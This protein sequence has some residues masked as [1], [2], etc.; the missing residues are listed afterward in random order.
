M[1]EATLAAL[2]RRVWGDAALQAQLFSMT[3]AEAF[4]AA[5]RELARMAGLSPDALSDEEIRQ[6]MV[7]GRRGWI[8][9]AQ[10]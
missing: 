10:P 4:V 6:A 9:R 5:V 8:E 1:P 7:A 3:D 2:R